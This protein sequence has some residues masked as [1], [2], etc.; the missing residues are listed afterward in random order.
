MQKQIFNAM[1]DPGLW[2]Q[3]SN[4]A[5]GM[6]SSLKNFGGPITDGQFWGDV[7]HNAATFMRP[8]DTPTTQGLPSVDQMKTMPWSD[9]YQLR[10][11]K[12]LTQEDQNY[13]APYEHR[14]YARDNV[15]TPYDA[16]ENTV[17]T[18]GYT[19]YKQ[20]ISRGRSQPSWNE[21]GQ[22]ILGGWEG[23]TK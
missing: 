23:L 10:K 21:L 4:K 19:P 7:R 16:L 22:G 8:N 1:G 14:A 6:L 20:L 18:V 13:L 3:A 11:Q 9:L 2:Q 5:Q 17:M 12:G 15:R